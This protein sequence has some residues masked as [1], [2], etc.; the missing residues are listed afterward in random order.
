MEVVGRVVGV[1][2]YNMCAI[3]Y[4]SLGINAAGV[5]R[6][7]AHRV[8]IHQLSLVFGQLFGLLFVHVAVERVALFFRQQ[9]ATCIYTRRKSLFVRGYKRLLQTPL[10]HPKPSFAALS[11]RRLPPFV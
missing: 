9:H 11:D 1:H 5:A 6:R 8:A 10:R 7:H 2:I 3:L 4:R